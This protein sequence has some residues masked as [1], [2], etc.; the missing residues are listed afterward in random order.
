M[1]RRDQNVSF[2]NNNCHYTNHDYLQTRV[3]GK[4]I[5]YVQVDP[6]IWSNE[7]REDIFDQGVSPP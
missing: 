4:N 6:G 5:R 1:D 3:G 2:L 7:D